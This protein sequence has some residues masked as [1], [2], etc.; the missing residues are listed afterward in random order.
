MRFA[1][2]DAVEPPYH[3]RRAKPGDFMRTTLAFIAIAASVASAPAF[4]ASTAADIL[5]ANKAA[6]GGAAWDEYPTLNTVYNYSGMGMTGRVSS[7]MD[8]RTGKFVDNAE[9]GPI[10]QVQGFDGTSAWNKDPSGMVTPQNG[11]DKFQAINESYRDANL[12]WRPDFGGAQVTVDPQKTEAGKTY[13]VVT[14]VPKDGGPFDAWFDTGTHLLYRIEEKQ[15]P[16]TAI[17]TF[18]E[19]GPYADA[20]IPKHVY[21]VA[22]DGKNAQTMTLWDA[23]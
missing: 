2:V 4:A 9:I 12:W 18:T 13:D 1:H 23:R 16:V 21:Q 19:Y 7:I 6:S 15:G 14:F 3:L 10:K 11:A 8:L 5:A 17:T 20:L 22:S